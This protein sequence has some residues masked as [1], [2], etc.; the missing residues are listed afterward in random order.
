MP[1]ILLALLAILS[2]TACSPRG[3]GGGGGGGGTDDP[4]P[5][6]GGEL[7][8]R[9]LEVGTFDLYECEGLNGPQNCAD[10]EVLFEVFHAGTET[11]DTMSRFTFRHGDVEFTDNADCADDPWVPEPGETLTDS[12]AVL[13]EGEGG[14]PTL[15]TPCGASQNLRTNSAA[16]PPENGGSVEISAEWSGPEA[17]YDAQTEALIA[18]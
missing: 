3:G 5:I 10:Y 1:R 13:W 6:I 11:V 15:F 16:A 17:N 18:R 2:T 12:V 8:L 14:Q 7:E 9:I 4:V